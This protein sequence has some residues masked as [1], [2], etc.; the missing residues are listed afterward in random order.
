MRGHAQGEAELRETEADDDI[1]KCFVPVRGAFHN[2]NLRQIQL[3]VLPAQIVAEA[4]MV[5]LGG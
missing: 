2:T 3:P 5:F 4:V 1:G